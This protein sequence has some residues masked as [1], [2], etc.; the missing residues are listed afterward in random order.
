MKTLLAKFSL[1]GCYPFGYEFVD[2]M[3]ESVAVMLAKNFTL[4]AT[5]A[6]GNKPVQ[7]PGR[8]KMPAQPAAV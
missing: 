1:S 7:S 3:G 8:P 2:R 4:G 6:P 5:S